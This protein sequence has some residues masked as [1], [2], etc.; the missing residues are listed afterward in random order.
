M[1]QVAKVWSFIFSN[2]PSNEYLRLISFKINWFDLLSVQESSPAPNF[3][4]I[5]SLVLSLL[6]GPTLTSLPDH[7]KI[8]ALTI[9]TFVGKVSLLFNSLSLSY[10]K[11]ID[12]LKL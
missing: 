10:E 11:M 8:I 12:D 4:S 9:W 1:H 2:S 3:E 7:W 6:Y 5:D